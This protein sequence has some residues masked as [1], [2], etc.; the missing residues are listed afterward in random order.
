MRGFGAG[1]L[2]GGVVAV[3]GL[4]VVSLVVP[5]PEGKAPVSAANEATAP[6]V[7]EPA[8]S[9]AAETAPE[10]KPE[11]APEV[12]PA[13]P[14]AEAP[15]AEA[16]AA[17]VPA[18][19]TPEPAA[20]A[21]PVTEPAAVPAT[22][23]PAVGAP[24]PDA[25]APETPKPE[26]ESQ[27]NPP[28]QTPP[29]ASTTAPVEMAKPAAL[30]AAPGA[31]AA[32]APA[33]DTAAAQPPALPKASDSAEAAPAGSTN[34]APP[35]AV[36]AEDDTPLPGEVPAHSPLAP[37]AEPEQAAAKPAEPAAPS[38]PLLDRP[39]PG[40]DGIKVD[41]V[42]TNRLPRIEA[43]AA[44]GAEAAAK[45]DP[46]PVAR[47]AAKFDNPQG[48]PRFAVLLIDDG[49]A[50]IDRAALASIPLPVTI[51]L[52]PAAPDVAVLEETYRKSGKE[53]AMLATQIPKGAAPSD[54][55]VTFAAHAKMLPQAVAVVDLPEGGFQ[56][57]RQIATDLVPVIKDQGRGLV[58]FDKGLN[59]GDQVARREAVPA[60][61]VFRE[62]DGQG[63]DGAAMRRHLDRAAFKAAQDGRVAVLGHAKSD[64]IAALLE[65]SVEGRAG[66]VALA[67]LTAVLAT[68]E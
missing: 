60:A 44:P 29:A 51:V 33:P 32:T 22:D 56:N 26:P 21:E 53:V 10:A 11:P 63:E 18:T 7:A 16:P 1:I 15:A 38:E 30:P 43:P 42:T 47:F 12:K 65:W 39:Q 48:K 54:L 3:L 9:E 31:S 13:A 45:V 34:P 28:V 36:V 59:A 8:T 5:L 14:A 58:T 40:L 62:L 37:A 4:G 66:S 27:V 20:T 23:T 52:D 46:R 2:W 17:T 64:T 24:K 6:E 25:P 68:P 41:G 55:A 57:S 67:P 61:M 50:Q 49:K 19:T 35:P